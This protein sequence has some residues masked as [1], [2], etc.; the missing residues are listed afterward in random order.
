[1]PAPPI[2]ADFPGAVAGL[3]QEI[4]E[5]IIGQVMATGGHLAPNLGVVELTMALH[6]VFNFE[7]DR[8]L[9]DVGHQCY[10]HKILTGRADRLSTLRQTGGMAGFPEPSE[11][12]FDLFSVGHAGTGISTAV[13]MA[14]GDT[15]QGEGYHSENNP[16]GR[17]TVALVGDASIVN[18]L[19]MEGLNRGHAGSS[20]LIVL[21]DSS[22][23]ISKPQGGFAKRWIRCVWMVAIWMRSCGPNGWPTPSPAGNLWCVGTQDWRS[24][25][26]PRG[27][28]FLVR[29]FWPLD[30]GSCG[31]AR[32]A[33][34]ES[35]LREVAKADRP[36]VL[37][38]VKGKV[39]SMPKATPPN[40]TRHRPFK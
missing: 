16:E 30:R 6:R 11:S 3:A 39:L 37:H 1:M 38:T 20:M 28:G 34:T 31:W 26:R 29:G 21:N 14:R 32:L 25:Q 10:P 24:G 35:V 2:F 18:G 23:S 15:L 5:A 40:S 4:R 17:R 36:I 22:M 9:F 19:A 7:H 8:L 13:G 33:Q 27:R 12:P